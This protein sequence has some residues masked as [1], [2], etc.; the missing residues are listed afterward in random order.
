MGGL[1]GLAA[2]AGGR[3]KDLMQQPIWAFSLRARA[4]C[5]GAS[6]LHCWTSP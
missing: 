2:C 4:L 3:C 5:R 1:G 6:A